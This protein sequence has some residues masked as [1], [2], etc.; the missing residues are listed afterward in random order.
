MSF[1]K[2]VIR[3]S[4]ILAMIL[5]AACSRPQT[6][7]KSEVTVQ[8]IP[9][10]PPPPEALKPHLSA[11]LT[12]GP[13]TPVGVQ[14]MMSDG[15]VQTFP[16][17][18]YVEFA[19][20]GV[21]SP[22][23]PSGFQLRGIFPTQYVG[24]IAVVQPDGTWKYPKPGRNVQVWRNGVLQRLG[25]DYTLNQAGALITPVQYPDA[26]NNMVGWNTDD[27]VTVAYLY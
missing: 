26:N 20:G 10:P 24:Q 15:T 9:T 2:V 17:G 19:T 3:T 4:G 18:I 12:A 1:M 8:T 16:L 14:V 25:P 23:C 22:A 5:S 27:Y 13:V 7:Q 6:T 21:C 11:P